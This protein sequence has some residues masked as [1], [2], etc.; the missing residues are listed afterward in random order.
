MVS[1]MA[2]KTS[3]RRFPGSAFR[4][5]QPLSPR[6]AACP[7]MGE[8]VVIASPLA[9][10][11]L[12]AHEEL[13]HVK[14]LRAAAA[15]VEDE[16]SGSASKRR[17]IHV[18]PIARDW[19]RLCLGCST[20]STR[21]LPTAGNGARHEQREANTH[22][23]FVKLCLLMSAHAASANCVANIDETSCRLLPVHQIG[24]GRPRRQTGPGAGQHKGGH[25][26]HGW[27]QQG[28]WPS[29]H[30]GADRQIGRSYTRARQTPSCRS[31]L[32]RS[33]LITSRQRTAGPRRPRSCSSRPHWPT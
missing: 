32:G 22:R 5:E 27:L 26:I 11:D 29:G 33:T 20:G 2:K 28:P 14:T 19:L 21:T 31:S 4:E 24:W 1:W 23:L 25:D 15:L 16:P 6:R 30:A 7:G 8:S 12:V 9:A 13:A 18:D 10:P 17:K 3:T